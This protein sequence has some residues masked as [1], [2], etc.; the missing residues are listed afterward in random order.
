[1]SLLFKTR[2]SHIW[3]GSSRLSFSCETQRIQIEMVWISKTHTTLLRNNK[4]D[5]P[6]KLIIVQKSTGTKLHDLSFWSVYLDFLTMISLFRLSFLLFVLKLST[7]T[8]LLRKITFYWKV[9]N[10]PLFLFLFFL[11]REGGEALLTAFVC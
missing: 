1:M 2:R 7:G 11:K 4:N 5:S 6:N 10:P 3:L 8:K 9:L